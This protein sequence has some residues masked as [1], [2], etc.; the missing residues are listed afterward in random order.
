MSVTSFDRLSARSKK[1]VE[2]EAEKVAI[3]RGAAA[4]EVDVDSA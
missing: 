2:A 3:L 4:V 1:V